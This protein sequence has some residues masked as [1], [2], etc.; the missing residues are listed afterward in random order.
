MTNKK[1][2][3]AGD[4]YLSESRNNRY[5][6]DTVYGELPWEQEKEQQYSNLKLPNDFDSM[7]EIL[8]DEYQQV[9]SYASKTI[10]NN[11]KSALAWLACL[12]CLALAWSGLGLSCPPCLGLR[13]C[14]TS[15]L[16][17]AP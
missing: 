4:I 8:T 11:K 7:M 12:L 17:H 2:I 16:E 14:P 9:A 15:S 6:W 13:P 3:S 5:F 1:E 10:K